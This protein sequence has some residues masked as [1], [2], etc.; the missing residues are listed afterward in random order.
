MRAALL[1][2][3]GQQLPSTSGRDLS[4]GVARASVSLAVALGAA[5]SFPPLAL[6]HTFGACGGGR[7]PLEPPP[8]AVF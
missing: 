5:A 2:R 1:P 8:R 7:R 6:F 3:G 4:G